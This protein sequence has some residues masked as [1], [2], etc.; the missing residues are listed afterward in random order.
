MRESTRDD[1]IDLVIILA[2]GIGGFLAL[3]LGG[4][5][6]IEMAM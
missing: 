1:I 3:L 6:W 5:A 2:I 4:L